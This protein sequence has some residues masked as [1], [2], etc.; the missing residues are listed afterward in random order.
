MRL[1]LG[2]TTIGGL[3]ELVGVATG[4]PFGSYAYTNRWFP[5]VDVPSLGFYPLLLPLAWF[6]VVGGC[7]ALASR[8]ARG[9][10]PVPLTALL[11]A[12]ADALVIEPVMA[13]PLAYWRWDPPGPLP[14]GAPI[15]NTLGWLGV[16]A[17]AAAWVRRSRGDLPETCS[18]PVLVL[19]AFLALTGW[20]GLSGFSGFGG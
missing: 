6:L 7:Y 13:G 20:I 16:S 17:L 8:L 9:H 1:V 15:L 2:A 11:A 19:G 10:W 4:Y 18:E 12:L 5:V 3:A 14:G